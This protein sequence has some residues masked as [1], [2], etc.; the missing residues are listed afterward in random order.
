[1]S[2]RKY[3]LEK[4][5]SQEQLAHMSGLSVRTVQRIE[6]GQ[7]AGLESLKCLAA[8]FETNISDL[9]KEVGLPFFVIFSTKSTFSASHIFA[10]RTSSDKI[11]FF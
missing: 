4:G 10:K 6:Q 11:S 2:V 3:R 9:I 5:W 1:M 8:V 7:K